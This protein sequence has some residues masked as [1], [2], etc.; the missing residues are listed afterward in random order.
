M[1][2]NFNRSN[3][4]SSGRS[5]EQSGFRPSSTNQKKFRCADM[6]YS[7]CPWEATGRE[8]EL[9][10]K[11]EQHGR[12]KHNLKSFDATTRERVRNVFKNVA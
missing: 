3:E 8:E 5:P 6:G 12:E 2:D 7:D 1:P 10:P 4:P 11:I 9:Y